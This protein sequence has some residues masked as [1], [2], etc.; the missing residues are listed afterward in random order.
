MNVEVTN[1]PGT[2]LIVEDSKGLNRM[3]Q[4]ALS[5]AGFHTKGVFTGEEAIEYAENNP[6]SLM[7]L[8]FLLPDMTGREVIEKL[9]ER[10]NSIPFILVTGHGDEKIA[11]EMMKLGARDYLVK[12]SGFLDMLIP[13]VEKVKLQLADEIRL[14]NAEAD[15]RESEE[16]FRTIYRNIPVPAFTWKRVDGSFVLVDYN[17]AALEITAG[18]IPDHVGSKAHVIHAK[19]PQILEDMSCCFDERRTIRRDFS[20]RMVTTGEDKYFSVSYVF[21]PPDLVICYAEDIT[22]RK[23][24]ETRLNDYALQMEAKS[25]KLEVMA[26]ELLQANEKLKEADRTKDE[27]ISILAHDLG[28]PIA[29]MKGNLDLM[30]KGVFGNLTEKQSMKLKRMMDVA[31]RLDKLRCDTLDLSR[32]A[33]GVMSIEKETVDIGNLINDAV[34]DIRRLADE[35][36]QEVSLEVSARGLILCDPSKIRQVLDNFLSNAVRYSGENGKIVVGGNA[37]VE[38]GTGNDILTIW[39]KDN[40]RGLP[41]DKLDRVFERFF[42]T[43]ER[44]KGSTGLGLSIVKGIV[45]AHWQHVDAESR[46]GQSPDKV[47]GGHAWCESEGEGKGT[48]FFFSLPRD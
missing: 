21:V 2:I 45:E 43:G 11:V 35:K 39:V 12:G 25:I 37:G 14:K 4:G 18:N 31:T 29:V 47:H 44:V 23:E 20:H 41:P 32:I 17:A 1:P 26:D 34:D 15:L 30:S 27:F 7:L 24:S 36:N 16:N 13:I 5:D 40:G 38:E 42:R 22:D 6:C 48:T 10:N 33:A 8:D 9:E 3:V 46:L 28:T 19:E